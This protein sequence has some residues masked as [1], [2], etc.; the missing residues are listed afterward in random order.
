MFY[1]VARDSS[2]T[3]AANPLARRNAVPTTSVYSCFS[4]AIYIPEI[5]TLA[6]NIDYRSTSRSSVEK[7]SGYDTAAHSASRITV[8]P[9]APSAAMANAMAMR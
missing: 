7:N 9:S 2:D 6:R 8:S 1:A 5:G 3:D 4:R